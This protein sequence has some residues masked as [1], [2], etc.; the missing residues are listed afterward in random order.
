MV[1]KTS[2]LENIRPVTDSTPT[3]ATPD[4]IPLYMIGLSISKYACLVSKSFS[5]TME[6]YS[7]AEWNI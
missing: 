4:F 6:E 5:C 1:A 3:T 2:I 7:F